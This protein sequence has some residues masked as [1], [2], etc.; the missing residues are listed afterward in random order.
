[1]T[2]P[3]PQGIP[4]ESEEPEDEYRMSLKSGSQLWCGQPLEEGAHVGLRIDGRVCGFQKQGR[5]TTFH[6]EVLDAEV[7]TEGRKS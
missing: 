4:P 6:I 3:A 1:M 5:R 2:K 7:L